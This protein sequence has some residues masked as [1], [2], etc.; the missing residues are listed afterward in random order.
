MKVILGGVSSAVGKTTISTGIMKA[1]S[2]YNVQPFKVGP[3]YIDPSYHTTA[4][5]NISKNLDSFFMD[6][7]QIISTYNRAMKNS[8]AKYGVIEGVRGLYE[9]ISPI[10]DVGSTA[11]I[12]KTLN[13]PII[14][15][16]DS[17]S[18]VKSA[19]A[20]VLG[21][22][23]LDPE[24]KIE[25]II[26]NK[27][28]GK[29]HYLKTKKS[30]EILTKTEVIGGIPRDDRIAVEGRHLGLIPS[31]EKEGIAKSIESWGRIVEEHIDL[32]ALIDIMKR[33]KTP[34]S[35]EKLWKIGNKKRLRIGLAKDEAFNFYYQDNIDALKENNAKIIQ[36]SPLHDENLPDVDGLYIGGGYPEI[37]KKELKKNS[38]IRES[39][40]K[41][42]NDGK[43]IYGECG[44]LIYLSRSIDKVKM[45]GVVPFDSVMTP[46]V[47]GL[48]Y[49]ITKSNKDNLISKRDEVFRGHEFHYTKLNDVSSDFVFEIQ[50][51]RGIIDGHDGLAYKNTLANYIHIHACSCPNFAYNFTRNMAENTDLNFSLL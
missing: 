11:S 49:T 8:K 20:I 36:F 50:R 42:H 17:R 44:G 40:L 31:L 34:K 32:D 6:D 24:L 25:G 41:F 16:L 26:L 9:G 38:S 43:Y 1:L 14:L 35:E 12:A 47:Q 39:I 15:I 51:G 28:K 29:K 7:K 23:L 2:E 45:C 33:F 10:T 21:F 19:A 22:K 48:S 27:V 13:A 46:K 4:T 5:G 37:F 3:D 18:L 30:V